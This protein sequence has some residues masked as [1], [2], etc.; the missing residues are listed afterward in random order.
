MRKFLTDEKH[1]KQEIPSKIQI[2]R[3]R[4]IILKI[5]RKWTERVSE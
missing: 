1:K 2:E 5:L 3:E 4:K